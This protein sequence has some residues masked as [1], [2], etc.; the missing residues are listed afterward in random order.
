[1]IYYVENMFSPTEKQTNFSI[2]YK[3]FLKIYNQGHELLNN[4]EIVPY[5][6]KVSKCNLF[7]KSQ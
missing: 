3:L 1:M 5:Q 2:I 7:L 6:N 4:E